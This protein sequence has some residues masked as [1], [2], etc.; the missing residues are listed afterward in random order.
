MR[1]QQFHG[2]PPNPLFHYKFPILV[3]YD[4]GIFCGILHFVTHSYGK[5]T[6]PKEDSPGCRA[7]SL[8][9]RFLVG[10]VLGKNNCFNQH[11]NL[12]R[13]H[14]KISWAMKRSPINYQP[15]MFVKFFSSPDV[16]KSTEQGSHHGATDCVQQVSITWSAK[17]TEKRKL[18]R[19]TDR[20]LGTGRNEWRLKHRSG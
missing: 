14:K 10:S 13:N 18:S 20:N 5:R 3:S 11:D 7:I 4:R 9:D 15:S 12:L 16:E 17:P 1:I 2:L 19:R 8:G 6:S